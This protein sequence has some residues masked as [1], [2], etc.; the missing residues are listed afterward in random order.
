MSAPVDLKALE[1]ALATVAADFSERPF[2]VKGAPE[3][4]AMVEAALRSTP[5]L[6]AA[7]RIAVSALR[8]AAS[9]PD[10]LAARLPARDALAQIAEKVAL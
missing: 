1:A 8:N 9:A 10:G 3:T 5:A 2:T 6:I 4:V 7:L